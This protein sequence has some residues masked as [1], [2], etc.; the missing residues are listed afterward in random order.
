MSP[1]RYVGAGNEQYG[2]HNRHSIALSVLVKYICATR[3][4][5]HRKTK[6]HKTR[7]Q[8]I[9]LENNVQYKNVTQRKQLTKLV[10]PFYIGQRLQPFLP[11]SVQS[12]SV[13]ITDVN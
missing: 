11:N 7:Q 8:L 10:H 6:W 13:L 3:E 2:A 1:T 4:D 5:V 12:R 9:F